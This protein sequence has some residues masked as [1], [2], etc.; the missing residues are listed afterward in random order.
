MMANWDLTRMPA[1]L[2]RVTIPALLIVG[3]NDRA[4]PPAD[5]EKLAKMLPQANIVRLPGLGHL[6]HEE[7]PRAVADRV[8]AEWAACGA[9]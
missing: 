5:A 3:A 2:R 1:D 7:N 4:I 6:A 9:D 8:L